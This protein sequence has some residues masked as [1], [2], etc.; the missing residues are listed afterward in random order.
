MI[1]TIV[2]RLLLS[3]PVLFGVLALGFVLVQVA[4]GDPARGEGDLGAALRSLQPF[5]RI[6]QIEPHATSPGGGMTRPLPSAI[7]WS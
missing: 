4:P 7:R 6:R 3:I 2:N 1:E 5:Q